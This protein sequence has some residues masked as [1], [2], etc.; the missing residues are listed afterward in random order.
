MQPDPEITGPLRSMW[1]AI[2]LAEL[3]RGR[4]AHRK[5]LIN[6]GAK[7]PLK[8]ALRRPGASAIACRLHVGVE[9]PKRERRAIDDGLTLTQPN[10]GVRFAGCP[11]VDPARVSGRLGNGGSPTGARLAVRAAI[12]SPP[13]SARPTGYKGVKSFPSVTWRRAPADLPRCDQRARRGEA[14]ECACRAQGPAQGAA[15]FPPADGDGRVELAP[16]RHCIKKPAIGRAYA[17]AASGQ[18]GRR[19][20]IPLRPGRFGARWRDHGLLGAPLVETQSDARR[21]LDAIHAIGR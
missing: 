16:G 11:S 20:A 13:R 2:G 9:E 5:G 15:L 8:S 19:E 17:S 4:P 12:Q 21:I 7:V 3:C 10:G 18:S 14:N 6:N 1:M